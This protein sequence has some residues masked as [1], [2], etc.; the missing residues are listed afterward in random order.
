[1]N[2]ETWV[3]IHILTM[4]REN[5][6]FDGK[7][8]QS[9]VRKRGCSSSSSSSLV[10]SYRL[11]RAILLGKRSGGSSIPVRIWKRMSSRSPS[12]KNGKYLVA[13]VGDKAKDLSI[14]ARKLATMLREINGFSSSRVKRENSEEKISELG[15]IRKR[16]VLKVLKLD[17]VQFHFV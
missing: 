17:S 6:K 13:N 1:M 8:G 7:I 11:K 14:T 5:L 3:Q 10:R 9:K 15:I 16:G 12:L 4:P 2:F